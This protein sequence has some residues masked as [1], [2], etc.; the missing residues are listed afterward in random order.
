MIREERLTKDINKVKKVICKCYNNNDYE[1][2]L[3]LMTFLGNFLYQT[4]QKYSDW[5]LEKVLH[6]IAGNIPYEIEQNGRDEKTVLFY[7]SFGLDTRGLALI[8]VKALINSGFKVVYMAPESN[9][10]CIP[11]ILSEIKRGKGVAIFFSEIEKMSQIK[12]LVDIINKWKVSKYI[13]YIKP[14]DVVPVVLAHLV[15]NKIIRFLINLTDHAFWLGV[16]A[17]DY[18]IEFRDYGCYISKEK[19]KIEQSKIVKL[20]YYPLI[21]EKTEFQGFPFD[22]GKNK[23]MFSG[24]SLYKTFGGDG[25]Y[26]FMVDKLLSHNTDLI[27]WYAG[28]GD[29]TEIEQLKRKYPERVYWTG[30]RPDLYQIMS[31]VDIYLNTY[32]MGGGLMTQY[33]IIAG[34]I[35]LTLIYDDCGKGFVLDNKRVSY[36]FGNV[37]ELIT[38][39]NEILEDCDFKLA[40]EEELKNQIIS[41][42]VFEE[43]LNDILLYGKS[44]FERD[45]SKVETKAFQRTYLERLSVYD[46]WAMWADMSELTILKY[47]VIYFVRGFCVK[48]YRGIK[49]RIKYFFR[50]L[51]K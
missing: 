10:N 20:P 44:G 3:S 43:E 29:G 14:Y 35:P 40:K 48:V 12:N 38:Y 21:D 4:N 22:K 45:F 51:K 27:F 6:D 33:S 30:E 23:V 39:A 36:E 17:I 11:H 15:K 24:G 34:K 26:Y 46:Y 18:C 19:R 47:F 37:N 49:K 7:D 8:Y 5:D 25:L 9:K 16:E 32:P 31:H 28:F 42:E 1:S 50:N 41:P 13:L 2:I